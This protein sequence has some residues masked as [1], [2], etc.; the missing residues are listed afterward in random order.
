MAIDT[1]WS[2][3]HV[4]GKVTPLKGDNID[5]LKR[6]KTKNLPRCDKVGKGKNRKIPKRPQLIEA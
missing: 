1:A 3:I 2:V 4:I 5:Y 6:L